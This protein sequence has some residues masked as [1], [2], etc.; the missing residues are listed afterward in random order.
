[1]KMYVVYD[2]KTGRVLHTHAFYV[3]GHDEPVAATEADVLAA[4]P[5]NV[6]DAD[7]AVAAVPEDFDVRSRLHT[8]RIDPRDGTVTVESRQ[9]PGPERGAE[10]P[11]R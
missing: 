2:R 4:T 11:G 10:E 1:M 9:R 7:C 5:E 6:R 8:L 3:L